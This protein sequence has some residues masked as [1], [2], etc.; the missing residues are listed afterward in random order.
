M[1]NDRK[2]GTFSNSDISCSNHKC[3]FRKELTLIVT[4]FKKKLSRHLLFVTTSIIYLLCITKSTAFCYIISTTSIDL[5]KKTK[6]AL[7]KNRGTD[8]PATI[9]MVYSS[10]I[11]IFL[12]PPV[13]EQE[14][15][16]Y[17]LQTRQ[18]MRSRI[19]IPLR[20][21]PVVLLL[22]LSLR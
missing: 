6:I 7:S 1:E 20:K 17:V 21:T 4:K 2:F 18:P 14:K 19:G 5:T 3:D 10:S 11:H 13:K 9:A 16:R 12:L 22:P 8:M 15:A